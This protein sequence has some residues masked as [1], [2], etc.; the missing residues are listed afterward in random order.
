[1]LVVI[2]DG[3]KQSEYLE[4]NP[5]PNKGTFTLSGIVLSDQLIPLEVVNALG[6]TIYKSVTST[7]DK[8]VNVTITIPDVAQGEYFLRIRVSNKNHTYRFIVSK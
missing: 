7:I 1:L 2:D 8:R 4:I 5:N 6:Q 3:L